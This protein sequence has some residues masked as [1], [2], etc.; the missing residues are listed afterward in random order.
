MGCCVLRRAESKSSAVMVEVEVKLLGLP[1]M[2]PYVCNITSLLY[3]EQL[4]VLA[5]LGQP[6][7]WAGLSG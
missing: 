4:Q 3:V 1:W 5:T 7:F 6:I 2:L